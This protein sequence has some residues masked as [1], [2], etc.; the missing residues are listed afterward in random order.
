ME[1]VAFL[2]ESTG[3]RIDCL[4]NPET[5]SVGR[6]AGV[7]P[8]GTGGGPMVGAGRA[9]DPLLLTGG[10]HT[11]LQ[12]DLLFDVDFVEPGIAP[13]DVRALTRPLWMLAENSATERGSVRPPKVRLV[14]GKAWNVPGIVAAVAERFDAFGADG[15]PRRSWLR[16]KLLRVT[17]SA[18]DA[19]DEF[20]A[21]LAAATPPPP[22][23]PGDAGPEEKSVGAI[24]AIGDG[25]P[26]PGFSGV[27]F[28]LV[29]TDAL[30]S[31]FLWRRLAEHNRLTNPLDVPP[32][33]VL[34]VPAVGE[35]F[36]AAAASIGAGGGARSTAPGSGG[37]VGPPAG[38]GP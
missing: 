20:A 5:L 15:V 22:P 34:S 14:W 2:V 27:R 7:R 28:D 8:R 24:A 1:R 13:P 6:S 29:A 30:G 17:E 37:P 16:M 12:L 4:L 26:E 18:A 35:V 19:A 23:G 10:G 38:S 33:T 3:E 21:R 32:G 36:A 9:D 25:S 11:E 31:P